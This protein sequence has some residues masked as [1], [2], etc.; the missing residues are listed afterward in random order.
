METMTMKRTPCITLCAAL[1]ASVAIASE[2]GDALYQRYMQR[3]QDY[4]ERIEQV[5]SDFLALS[6]KRQ[7]KLVIDKRNTSFF[8]N[9]GKSHIELKG[10]LKTFAEAYTPSEVA[11]GVW[12]LLD[13]PAHAADIAAYC[14]GLNGW[15]AGEHAFGGRRHR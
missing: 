13:D 15:T 14:L 9:N 6:G 1:L 8:G 3:K 4:A 11:A 5:R 12:D 2:E 7:W 10:A